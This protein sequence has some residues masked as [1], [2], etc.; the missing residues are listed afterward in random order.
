MLNDL[1][2]NRKETMSNG[3]FFFLFKIYTNFLEIWLMN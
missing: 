1:V 3:G 2:K